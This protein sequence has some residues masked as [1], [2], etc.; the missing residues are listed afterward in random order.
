M[1]EMTGTEKKKEPVRRAVVECI[2]YKDGRRIERPFGEA[3]RE[4]APLPR[5]TVAAFTLRRGEG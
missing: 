4:T 1:K 3:Q 5:G 2:E